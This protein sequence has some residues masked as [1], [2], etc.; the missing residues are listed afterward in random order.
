MRFYKRNLKVKIMKSGILNKRSSNAEL[1]RI[2]AIF[3]IVLSHFSFHGFFSEELR[4]NWID[5][6]VNKY[7][8][9]IVQLG[10]LG[11]DIFV[12]ISGYYLINNKI[13]RVSKVLSLLAQ[14]LFYAIIIIVLLIFLGK[15]VSLMMAFNS[16]TPISSSLYWFVTCYVIL[17]VLHPYLNLIVHNFT[18]EE[19]K[20]NYQIF[21]GI[22]IVLFAVYYTFLNREMYANYLVQFIFLYYIGGYLRRFSFNCSNLSLLILLSLWLV[23]PYVGYLTGNEGIINHI[24]HFFTRMSLLTLAL[25][26]AIFCKFVIDTPAYHHNFINKV[27][28][29]S[30]AIY[31]IHDNPFSR[32]VIYVDLFNLKSYANE[33]YMPLLFLSDA[34]LI[35]VMG[36]VFDLFRQ[37][38]FKVGEALI[39]KMPKKVL[40]LLKYE[41]KVID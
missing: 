32:D 12:I 24:T 6:E 1:L 36:V 30:L 8:L 35:L 18:G 5:N 33:V 41:Y 16:L 2:I 11:V 20:K 37:S 26:V 39:N 17:Y 25:A 4:Y 7:F 31:L 38:L 21:L 9:R 27:A 13:M 10:S 28:S 23:I 15:P 3:M 40:A 29:T 19:E 14:V 34:M 22:M